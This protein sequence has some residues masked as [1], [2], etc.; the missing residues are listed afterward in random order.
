MV[1]R[2]TITALVLAA[3]A[4]PGVAQTTWY[5]DGAGTPPGVGTPG[6]PYTS[7]QFALQQPTTLDGDTVLVLPGT[8][9]ENI[10]LLGKEVLLTSQGGAAAT[11]LDGGNASPV[12]TARLG[13]G[14]QTEV[15]GFTIQNGVPSLTTLPGGGVSVGSTSSLTLTDCVVRQ[16]A[17]NFGGGIGAEQGV[18]RLRLTG[19]T[20]EQNQAGPD[21]MGGTDG[22]G[23]GVYAL[24]CSALEIHSSVIRDNDTGGYGGGVCAISTPLEVIDSTIEAN[25]ATLQGAGGLV[26]RGAGAYVSNTTIEIRGSRVWNNQ[27]VGSHTSGGGLALISVEGRVDSCWIA[28]NGAGDSQSAFFFGTG[29]G[30]RI[31]GVGSD[32]NQPLRFIDTRFEGNIANGNGG[33]VYLDPF[34][35]ADTVDFLRCNFTQNFAQFGGGLYADSGGSRVSDSLI[36]RNGPFGTGTNNFGAGVYGPIHVVDSELDANGCDGD[37]GGAHSATL[38]RCLIHHNVVFSLECSLPARGAGAYQ[39]DLI[40]CLVWKNIAA[41]NSGCGGAPGL[42]GG[43]FGGTALRCEIWA[44]ECITGSE[45]GEGGG[46]F[47]T[48]LERCLLHGNLADVGAG[49]EF[50]SLEH[51]TVI[52][53]L[54]EG[55]NSATSV[56]NSIVRGNSIQL[57]ATPSV[58]YSNIEG[59]AVGV[60]NI[61]ALELF[62]DPLGGPF[63][64]GLDAHFDSAS[65]PGIDAGDPASPLDPDG[66]RADLGPYPYDASWCSEPAVYCSAKYIGVACYPRISSEGSPSLSGTDDFHVTAWQIPTKRNGIFFWGLSS[67]SIP[68]QGGV[69]CV[70]PPTQRTPPSNSAGSATA[71]PCLGTFDHHFSQ[72]AM[73]AGGL[74]AGTRVYGQF[75]FRDLFPPSGTGLSNAVWWTVCP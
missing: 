71:N 49:V 20:V 27:V 26:A 32:P 52:D 28:G 5:V 53:H 37:G 17:A 42:G 24:E 68:F 35:G 2:I 43:L 29:G 9:F 58:T 23:G 16:C 4:V 8:Y 62:V 44:N 19:C 70:A 30:A 66:T 67:A 54:G 40:D 22:G 18:V 13:E 6:S 45:L 61:N 39:C 14:L 72:S 3:L 46:A 25:T 59:G 41:G 73:A 7:I 47:L 60:G 75:W 34:G 55:V 48:T 50:G 57:V 11:T 15:E 64:T 56:R 33:G 69:L 31:S 65:S 10:D 36:E 74:S 51:C 21:F 12:I 38:E 1:H 63:G